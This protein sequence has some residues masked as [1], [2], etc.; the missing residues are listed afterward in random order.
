MTPVISETLTEAQIRKAAASVGVLGAGH[1]A[2]RILA[3]LS[4][5]RVNARDVAALISPEPGLS[6][7]VLRI[8]NS[9]FYGQS[10][11][12]STV[13]GALRLLGL[14]AVRG[15]A[16]AACMD[17]TLASK[18]GGWP[19]ELKLLVRHSLAT[20]I[21]AR[22]LALRHGPQYAGD[23]FIC[24]LLHNLGTAVQLQLDPAGLRAMLDA[25]TAGFTGGM[26]ALEEGRV[27]V[28]HERCLEVVFSAWTLPEALI[29]ACCHHHDPLGAPAAYAE[30]ASLVHL[31]TCV[32]LASGHTYALE[33]AAQAPLPAAMERLAI[34]AEQLEQVAEQLSE[35][36][37]ALQSAL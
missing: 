32:A 36:V 33:P 23:A 22:D 31:G 14:D 26:L 11:G 25:R 27:S 8:A 3:L 4:D 18:Q 28:G 1:A 13:E 35:R 21:A 19:M 17:R 6:V 16:A 34:S 29:A 24:G 2:P 37:E 10:R 5:P 15:I 7:R 20:A 30:L 12:I 9:A